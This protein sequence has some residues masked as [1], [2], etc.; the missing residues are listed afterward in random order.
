MEAK[1]LLDFIALFTL[2]ITF[3]AA[4]STYKDI[5]KSQARVIIPKIVCIISMAFTSILA[6]IY[7][8]A[9]IGIDLANWIGE[10]I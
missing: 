9:T 5:Y 7:V 8:Y 1:H 4:Q 10:S 3:W 6:W 2:C